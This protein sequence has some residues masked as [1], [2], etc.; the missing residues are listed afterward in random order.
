MK[1]RLAL[2]G[3][4]HVSITSEQTSMMTYKSGIWDD[5][6]KS[7]TATRSTDHAV[8]LVGYGTELS[9]TGVQMDYWIIQN[10]WGANWGTNGFM[11]MK[12][13]INLCLVASNVAYPVLKTV[14]PQPLTPIYTPTGCDVMQDV[15]SSTGVYIKS[16]C[17]DSFGRNYEN[18]RQDCLKKGMRLYQLDSP[19]AT[20]GVFNATDTKWTSN[21]MITELYVYGNT[22]S[23]CNIITNMNPFGPVT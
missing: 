1:C 15:F 19:D 2:H 22:N 8:T 4:M 3:P 21:N 7:C 18:S 14:S 23:V 9:Q 6:E 16:L 5:P 10:S 12:R 11:K 17:I 20:T 13:G